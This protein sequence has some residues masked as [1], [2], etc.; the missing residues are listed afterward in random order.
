MSRSANPVTIGLFVTGA[1]AILIGMLVFFGAT[2]IFDRR[3]RFVA[4]FDESVNGLN[5]GAAV[6]FKGVPIGRVVEIR[7]R[8]NQG[9]LSSAI[10]VIMEID[11]QRLTNDLGVSVNLAD[12]EQFFSQVEQ[13]LRAKLNSESFITGLLFVELDYFPDTP[14]NF[15][16]ETFVLNEIP[17]VPSSLAEIQRSATEA[18]AKIGSVNFEDIGQE[19]NTLL[20]LANDRLEGVDSRRI[21]DAVSRAGNAVA[22]LAESDAIAELIADLRSTLQRIDRITGGL[23]TEVPEISAA[24]RQTADKLKDTLGRLDSLLGS[25]NT[26]VAPESDVRYQLDRTLTELQ[27]AARALT[28]LAQFLERNPRALLTGRETAEP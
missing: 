1:F 18:I 15:V 6:K 13:G 7:I 19:V 20:T 9:A 27:T 5:I 16:Q 8:Y 21:S 10:P 25:A 23:E 28:D 4:Y 24:F 17:T 12:Q 11:T 2:K 14:M 3:E 26:L 22:E